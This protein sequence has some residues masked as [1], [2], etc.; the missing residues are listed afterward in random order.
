ML[1]K[2]PAVAKTVALM[3][4]AGSV[5]YLVG[6]K[7]LRIA[8]QGVVRFTRTALTVLAISY[9]YKKSLWNVEKTSELYNEL[10]SQVHSRSANQLRDLCFRNAGL[11][12]K[13]GQHLGSLDY[14]LP[15][16]YVQVLKIFHHTAPRSSLADIQQ[17]FKEEL[18]KTPVDLFQSFDVH[19][20][21]AA[22]LAQVH[23]AVL[24]DGRTVA[25]KV[26][27]KDILDHSS[28][29]VKTMEFLVNV[30]K[31]LFP[32]F[33]FSWL[34]EETKKNLPLELDF[35]N[36]GKNS[37]KLQEKFSRHTFLKVP[38]VYWNYSTK[39]ILTM[40]YCEGGHVNDL[41]YMR[42]HGISSDEVSSKVGKIYSEMIFVQGCI[43]CDPHPGNILIRKN[44][45]GTVE[46][47]MLDHGLYH[48]ITSNFRVNYCKMWQAIISADLDGIKKYSE[49]MGVGDQYGLFAC[50]L[51]ARTWDTVVNGLEKTPLSQN[52]MNELRGSIG[53]YLSDISSVLNRVPRQLL[54]ILKT[55]DLLRCIDHQL[56]TSKASRSFITMSK[57][58]VEAVAR[59]ELR[60]CD[61]WVGRLKTYM[62]WSIANARIALYQLSVQ[63]YSL[64]SDLWGSI[65]ANL[66]SLSLISL[67]VGVS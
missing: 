60:T 36:E 18:G 10:L 46:I 63:D 48:E 62:R 6:G 8:G 17:V 31:R 59:E 23:K 45:Q 24:K 29:D 21:G 25:V 15:E 61:S 20:L 66:F 44:S 38:E 27:H 35:L 55:N 52:E 26:Q 56:Q 14:M 42:D 40:E 50:M 54:L 33:Q 3:A 5:V 28:S 49:K 30:V 13:V 4:S 34:V 11:Y 53:F 37:E 16:E 41:Q 9:D 1:K 12:I 19:P 58:C 64:S 47:V 22:S 7:E 65:A 39:R 43:H 57:C 67:F 51:S 32:D 2:L